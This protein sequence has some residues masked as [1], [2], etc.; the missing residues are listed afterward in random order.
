MITSQRG[1][2][3]PRRLIRSLFDGAPASGQ[4]KSR[5]R[6]N[7]NQ[8]S[9]AYLFAARDDQFLLIPPLGESSMLIGRDPMK[10]EKY[11]LDRA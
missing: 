7:L 3:F 1:E 5:L 8:G 4:Q 11:T 10:A 2:V 9:R 6:R